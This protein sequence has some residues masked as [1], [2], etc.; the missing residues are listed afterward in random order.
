M[1]PHSSDYVIDGVGISKGKFHKIIILIMKLLYI[2]R[3]QSYTY[4]H[5]ARIISIIKF[6]IFGLLLF[7][8]NNTI[9][10]SPFKVYS[11]NIYCKSY[12]QRME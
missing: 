3:L 1:A 10:D 9:L 12:K 6:A 2:I 4:R 5:D 11:R 7:R 8:D